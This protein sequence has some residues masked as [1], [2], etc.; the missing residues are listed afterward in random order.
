MFYS[1]NPFTRQTFLE[2]PQLSEAELEEALT[3]AAR[4]FHKWQ[5]TNLPERQAWLM[6]L[7]S[8][9]KKNKD[10]LS[11]MITEEMGKP[12][13]EAI[14]EVEKSIDLIEYYA[15]PWALEALGAKTLPNKGSLVQQPLGVILGIMPWNFPVWQVI[16]FAIPTVL[17]GNVVVVKHAPQ[18]MGC[19]KLLDQLLNVTSDFGAIYTNLVIDLQQT[20]KLLADRRVAGVS[21]TGSV[22][23]GRAVAKACGEFLKPVVLELGGSDPYIVFEDADFDLAFRECWKSRLLNA[24]QSCIAAKRMLIHRK[25]IDR[26]R[27][28]TYDLFKSIEM[29]D[30]LS[31]STKLGPLARQELAEVLRSQIK[32]ALERG[33]R[34]SVQSPLDAPHEGFIAPQ[35]LEN[36]D[37]QTMQNEEFFGPV[38]M[39]AAFDSEQ[40]AIE[41]ANGSVFGLGAAIFSQDIERAQ[42]LAR[43]EIQAG[44]VF[45]NEMLRSDPRRPFGGIK[46]S[47][48]GREMGALGLSSFCNQ[49]T[50]NF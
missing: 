27:E 41:L 13:S 40:E 21:L 37:V 30:P 15:E 24:G 2:H 32:T 50:V 47:G 42:R 4:G 44:S 5:Q 38:A 33:A 22:K 12:L 48:F 9:F 46:D 18:T 16:R 39:M 8:E 23:A 34:V 45:I 20:Q 19:G 26:W 36:V 35:L 3:Q 6:S 29:G 43:D 17:A 31:S 28:R 1:V 49:K 10:S 7:S 14:A 11:K 25:W